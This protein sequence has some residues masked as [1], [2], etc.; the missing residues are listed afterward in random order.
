MKVVKEL[1]KMYK[2]LTK[3]WKKLLKGQNVETVKVTVSFQQ[4]RVSILQ[5]S[6]TFL[7]L[8]LLLLVLG[9]EGLF[10]RTARYHYIFLGE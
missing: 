5:L 4:T 7:P 9:V 3:W 10:N 1:G 2:E 8:L 6:F